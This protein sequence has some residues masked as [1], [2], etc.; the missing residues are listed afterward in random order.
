MY[1]SIEDERFNITKK[2]RYDLKKKG[3]ETWEKSKR[4]GMWKAM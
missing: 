2:K 4:R 1:L 3:W